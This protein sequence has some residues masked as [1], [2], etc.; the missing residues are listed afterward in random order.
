M[1]RGFIVTPESVERHNFEYRNVGSNGDRAFQHGRFQSA[2]RSVLTALLECFDHVT[3]AE[4]EEGGE[5]EGEEVEGGEGG[6]DAQDEGEEVEGGDQ[7]GVVQGEDQG[8]G[9]E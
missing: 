5:D 2:L 4:G 6:E 9:E 1:S 3:E 8:E 7:V